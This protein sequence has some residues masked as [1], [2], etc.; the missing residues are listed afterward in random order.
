MDPSVKQREVLLPDSEA[1]VLLAAELM[2]LVAGDEQKV[3]LDKA[4]EVWAE[5]FARLFR[6]LIQAG[7]EIERVLEI[8]PDFEQA[9]LHDLKKCAEGNRNQSVRYSIIRE[10]TADYQQC[11]IILT[12]D[13]AGDPVRFSFPSFRQTDEGTRYPL[14]E[15]PLI[16][17]MLLQGQCLIR[18]LMELLGSRQRSMT[19]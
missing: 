12:L 7:V 16:Q 11:T 9:V 13:G 19:G 8:F 6:Q 10:S 18:L 14:E 4:L 3:N 15:S 1:Q 17:N 2:I 5:V